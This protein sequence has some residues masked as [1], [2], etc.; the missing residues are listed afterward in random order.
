[1]NI[2]T[3]ITL[4]EPHPHLAELISNYQDGCTSPAETE[5]VEQHLLECE[6]CREYLAG[7]QQM[8]EAIADLPPSIDNPEQL[9]EEFRRLNARAIYPAE[10]KRYQRRKFDDKPGSNA[11]LPEPAQEGSKPETP[12]SKSRRA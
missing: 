3:R 12:E 5:L 8:R 6:H 11:K 10:R 9:R 4:G 1:M 2:S 7:L